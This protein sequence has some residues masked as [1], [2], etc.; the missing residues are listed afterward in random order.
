MDTEL[1]QESQYSQEDLEQY[2]GIKIKNS[3]TE[4]Y[5]KRT[6]EDNEEY[7]VKCIKIDRRIK[8]KEIVSVETLLNRLN[9]DV[10][11]YI[12]VMKR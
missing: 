9:A 10:D 2:S 12:L 4:C 11:N 3:N 1:K 8:E 7:W 6:N 5:L